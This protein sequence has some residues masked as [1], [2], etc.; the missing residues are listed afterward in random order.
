MQR[1]GVGTAL[2]REALSH[3]R[4][5]GFESAQCMA[6]SAHTQR[7][8]SNLGMRELNAIEYASY[9]RADDGERIFAGAKMGEHTRGM[10][11]AMKI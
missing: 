7:I 5:K 4:R 8:C 11:M 2:I 3:G 10:F 6:L 1:R 9:A